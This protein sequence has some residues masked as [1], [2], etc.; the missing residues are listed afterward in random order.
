MLPFNPFSAIAAKIYGALLIGALVVAAVQT[1]RIDGVWCRELAEGER[2]RCLVT[3]FVQDVADRDVTIAERTAERDAE[4]SSHQATKDTYRNAQSEAARLEQ[5]RLARV[6]AEQ[7]EIMNAAAQNYRDRIAAARADAERLRRAAG[8]G[9]SASSAGGAG[10]V[11]G[12]SVA[13][14]GTAAAAA[15][16]RLPEPAQDLRADIDWRLIATEQAVQLDELITAVERQAAID[17]NE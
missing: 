14:G 9:D 6:Q 4:R 15:G 8:A 3:G 5:A 10:P 2:S 17:P 7:Q 1:M 13:A 11:P 12:V 16:D